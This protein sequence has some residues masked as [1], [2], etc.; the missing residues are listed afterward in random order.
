MPIDNDQGCNRKFVSNQNYP[1]NE[2]IVFRSIR[3]VF[4]FGRSGTIN[5]KWEQKNFFHFLFIKNFYPLP[6]ACIASRHNVENGFSSKYIKWCRATGRANL[7]RRMT[8][9]DHS[10]METIQQ[11]F[12]SLNGLGTILRCSFGTVSVTFPQCTTYPSLTSQVVENL[13]FTSQQSTWR[14][15]TIPT[16]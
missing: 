9:N 3:N 7:K 5:L 8:R 12:K 4:F 2:P 11:S 13:R 1:Q 6:V 16:H 10:V 14:N 15:M